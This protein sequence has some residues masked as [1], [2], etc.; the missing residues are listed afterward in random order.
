MFPFKYSPFIFPFI[1]FLS[2]VLSAQS[3]KERDLELDSLRQITL[4][5]MQSDQY[6]AAL[7]TIEVIKQKAVE[8]N[9]SVY[10][11]ISEH[12]LGLIYTQLYAYQKAEFHYIRAIDLNVKRKDTI[13]LSKNYSN[14]LHVYMLADDFE[15]YN[16]ILQKTLLLDIT[17]GNKG[18]FYDLETQIMALYKQKQYDSLIVTAKGALNELQLINIDDIVDTSIKN[19][20]WRETI[21]LRL[22]L[23]FD[24]YLAYG[25]FESKKELPY[26]NTLLNKV[27]DKKLEEILWYSPRVFEQYY[28]INLYK[29]QYFLNQKRPNVDSIIHYQKNSAFY[30]KK[31]VSLLKEKAAANNDYLTTAIHAEKEL[32]RLELVALNKESEN[33]FAKKINYLLLFLGLLALAFIFYYKKSNTKITRINNSLDAN[34]LALKEN[35]SQRNKFLAVLSHEVRT[36]LYALQELISKTPEENEADNEELSLANY[37]LINLKHSVENAL[38]YSRLNYFDINVGLVNSPIHLNNLLKDQKEY[39]RP[40]LMVNNVH[41][42]LESELVNSVF[43]VSKSKLLIVLN[44][45]IKN[46]IEEEYVTEV[47][48]ILQEMPVSDKATKVKCT[49]L[50]NGPGI[51]EETIAYVNQDEIIIKDEDSQKGIQLGLILSNQ[52]LSL[53]DSKLVFGE[54]KGLNSVSFELLLEPSKSTPISLNTGISKKRKILY[55]D[56]NIINLLITKKIIESLN[57]E[58]HTL[59]SGYLAIERVKVVA[60]DMILMDINMPEING[61][62]TSIEIH[63]IN[64]NI[65]IV[66]YTALSE[67]EVIERCKAAHISEVLTKPLNANEFNGVLARYFNSL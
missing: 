63:K 15:S 61:Y 27:K 51:S 5:Q 11:A 66:A 38:Q 2:V 32:E 54:S 9:N 30:Y 19:K 47:T 14:L 37:S 21:A 17:V 6:F 18:R 44:N 40:L 26:A 3:D 36:P 48:I 29:E 16:A 42:K 24:M 33:T 50:D 10:M 60:Y 7:Q 39:F 64:K 49:V 59:N 8:Q 1:L 67:D 65:P 25:L 13:W 22:Q 31:T 23:T 62:E 57:H 43:K 34:N 20:K 12:D 46:A 58:C 28:R 45:L 41:L 4:M 53:Y 56:D 35:N 55:V 52:V